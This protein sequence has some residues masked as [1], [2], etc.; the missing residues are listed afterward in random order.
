MVWLDENH[1]I[2]VLFDSFQN[3]TLQIAHLVD[4]R[5]QLVEILL[6]HL[7]L[8]IWLSLRKLHED[9]IELLFKASFEFF[10]EE[11]LE[12]ERVLDGPVEFIEALLID[13]IIP[14]VDEQEQVQ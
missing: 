11:L 9:L 4:K 6:F 13:A 8:S 5:V 2:E 12:L 14:L 7:N 3:F 1:D 10:D